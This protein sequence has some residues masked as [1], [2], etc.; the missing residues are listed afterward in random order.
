MEQDKW[1]GGESQR[2]EVCVWT[3]GDKFG[4]FHLC[5]TSMARDLY[6]FLFSLHIKM[7]NWV[8]TNVGGCEFFSLKMLQEEWRSWLN[9]DPWYIMSQ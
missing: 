7:H 9:L 1:G 3:C 2:R 6:P 5:E 8:R 4:V